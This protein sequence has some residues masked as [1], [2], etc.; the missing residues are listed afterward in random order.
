MT[1]SHLVILAMMLLAGP[2]AVEVEAAD[3]T[4]APAETVPETAPE[5]ATP[6]PP[7]ED[8]ARSPDEKTT[9]APD[10]E[11][12]ASTVRRQLQESLD[13]LN[14]LRDR[15]RAESK[16]LND[17]LRSLEGE[18]VQ[19]RRQYREAT[20]L[21]D[22]RKLDLSNLR[23]EIKQRQE[24]ATYLSNLLGEYVRNFES[25]VHIAELKRYKEPLE[26]AKLA[27]ENPNLSRED[28]YE[29]Q[30]ALVRTSLERLH[31]TLGGTRFDGQAVD[32]GGGVKQGT[33]VLVGPA[34]LFASEDGQAVG[35]A[36]TR[37]GSFE[38]ALLP[39]GDPEDAEAA[40]TLVREGQGEFPL[41]ATL[42]N[43]H[44]IESTEETLVEHIAKGG[45]VMYPILA[46]AAAALLVALYKWVS[47]A[48]IRKPSRKRVAAL[49]NAIAE[50][51]EPAAREEAKAI[52]GPAGEMLR[53]GV[54]H[55]REPRELIE[56]V[57]YEKV[58]STRL[59]LQ[60]L[61]PFIAIA[62]SSAPLLGLLGTVTG[63]INTFKLITV[64]GS[65][66]VKTLSGG[67]SEALITT[68]FGLIVAIPSLLLYAFLSRK[69]R[70]I[71]DQMEKTAV[72]FANQVSKSLPARRRAEREDETWEESVP[73]PD[74]NGAAAPVA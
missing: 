30:L 74:P 60:Q 12:A 33:F 8:A 20:R 65:G 4:P 21:L 11:E 53:T 22:T 9:V 7:A 16:P 1:R 58:L 10:F 55:L 36:E 6:A 67:I 3:A 63:I 66:D 71:V 5:D 44:K 18:L 61:L 37:L 28:L 69:A 13:E 19:V 38:P 27:L 70:S 32:A 62:A 57:M 14:T 39:F 43:A 49:L 40:A 48:F 46:L 64:F 2:P 34:A 45:A 29:A 24:E 54:D 68:E 26:A 59:R 41:D 47:L 73:E 23:N 31:D 51:N 35:S 52:R 50:R 15:I 42:G 17:K 56:E 25:R 72:A